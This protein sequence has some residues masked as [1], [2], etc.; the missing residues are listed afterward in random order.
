MKD[1]EPDIWPKLTDLLYIK[2]SITYGHNSEKGKYPLD[3]DGSFQSFARTPDEVA[4]ENAPKLTGSYCESL[5]S[6]LEKIGGEAKRGE[7]TFFD[8]SGGERSP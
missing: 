1:G 7:S 2:P 5:G 6:A 3:V 4:L 8:H